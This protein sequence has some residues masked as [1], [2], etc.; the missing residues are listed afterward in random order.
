MCNRSNNISNYENSKEAKHICIL[1]LF[2]EILMVIIGS[3]SGTCAFIHHHLQY[4]DHHKLQFQLSICLHQNR[5]V[6][7]RK[8][9]ALTLNRTGLTPFGY[10][11]KGLLRFL[12]GLEETLSGP[13]RFRWWMIFH[14]YNWVELYMNRRNNFKKAGIKLQ[15]TKV[16]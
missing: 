9:R 16:L 1:C 14:L 13:V 15:T 10:S 3:S 8:R 7:V 11:Q 6:L 5:S 4:Y 12:F 2:R